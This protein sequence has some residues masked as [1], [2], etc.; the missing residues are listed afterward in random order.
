MSTKN[1]IKSQK[2]ML[3]EGIVSVGAK[4]RQRK[5]PD[6]YFQKVLPRIITFI[7]SVTVPV[8]FFSSR[9]YSPVS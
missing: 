6:N 8:V 9:V 5:I 3:R 7:V 2:I 1:K 4:F